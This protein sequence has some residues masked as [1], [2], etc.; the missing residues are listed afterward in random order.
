MTHVILW[1]SGTA[2]SQSRWNTKIKINHVKPYSFSQILGATNSLV[3]D[4]L[5]STF[6]QSKFK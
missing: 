4:V 5:V 3:R 2:L 1:N 6:M